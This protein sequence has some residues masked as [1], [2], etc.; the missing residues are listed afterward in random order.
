MNKFMLGS[1]NL[2]KVPKEKIK[3]DKNGNKWLDITI[4]FNETPDQYGNNCAIQVSGK[5]DESKVYIGN[6]KFYVPKEAEPIPDK[7]GQFTK[8]PGSD[9]P[10]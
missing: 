8:G 2:S 1:L 5:R 6:A 3:E 9:L 4:W 7:Q 10:F